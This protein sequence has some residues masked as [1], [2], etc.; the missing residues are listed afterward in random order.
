MRPSL[1]IH[2]YGGAHCTCAADVY[3]CIQWGLLNLVQNFVCGE[4]DL[5]FV[6]GGTKQCKLTG[7][8]IPKMKGQGT[9]L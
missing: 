8:D 4:W 7:N 1:D 2:Y 3:T 9:Q 6:K 5:S